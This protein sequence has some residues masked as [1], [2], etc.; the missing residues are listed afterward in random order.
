MPQ[1]LPAVLVIAGLDPSGGAGIQA[2][3][4]TLSALQCHC[5]PVISINTVQDSRKLHQAHPV[6]P[7]ILEQQLLTLE[8][9]FDFS[10]VKL[11]AL[12]SAEN[13]KVVAQS[14]LRITANNPSIAVILDPVLKASHGGLLGDESLQQTL[15]DEVIPYCTL[16]TPNEPEL[17][18][19][20][21]EPSPPHAAI[22]LAEL[23]PSVL[24]TGGHNRNMADN[25]LENT[26]TIGAHQ[27]GRA[28]RW[29]ITLVDGEF[30]GTGCTFSSAIAGY[31]AQGFS[32]THAIEKAQHFISHTLESAYILKSGQR[33]PLRIFK[34]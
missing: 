25:T 12:G 11:G 27:P 16:I 33:I 7:E 20:T 34:P 30:R 5:T 26:L 22:K 1:T 21:G 18:T 10:A 23:G 32:I 14:L 15:L 19:L 6:A 24:V 13:A 9:D 3:I 2:D 8:A 4:Q 29:L 31:M 28:Q 17:K